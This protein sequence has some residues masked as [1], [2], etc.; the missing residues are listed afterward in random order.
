MGHLLK[1]KGVGLQE[2]VEAEKRPWDQALRQRYS[3][4][5]W[6]LAAIGC[7]VGEG[8]TLEGSGEQKTWNVDRLLGSRFQAKAATEVDQGQARSRIGE[9]LFPTR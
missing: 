6:F 8:V 3:P 4:F 2:T 5:M 7:E 1:S 9:Y